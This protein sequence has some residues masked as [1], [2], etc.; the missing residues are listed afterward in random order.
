MSNLSILFLLGAYTYDP[1]VQIL[2]ST[3]YLFGIDHT[4]HLAAPC[5]NRDSGYGFLVIPTQMVSLLLQSKFLILPLRNAVRSPPVPFCQFS[6]F[7]RQGTSLCVGLLQLRLNFN[8][9]AYF[10]K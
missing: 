3:G 8:K 7:E 9:P 4:P 6:Y 1:A 10:Y 2:I 5:Q